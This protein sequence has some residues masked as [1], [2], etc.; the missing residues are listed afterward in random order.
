MKNGLYVTEKYI[1]L[2]KDISPYAE[3]VASKLVYPSYLSCEYV[4][5]KYN[6][7]TEA[8]YTITS[9]IAKTTRKIENFLGSFKY[10]NLKK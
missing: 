10:Y 2:Q 4:L 9:I 5:Q 1:L 3:F 7:L 6:I 8:V